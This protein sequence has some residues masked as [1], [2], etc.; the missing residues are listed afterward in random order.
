MMVDWTKVVAVEMGRSGWLT[1]ILYFEGFS[2]RLDVG[3]KV[4]EDSKSFD[5]N[6]FKK[7]VE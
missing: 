6:D 1:H 2:D 5:L 3:M 7:G 4:K